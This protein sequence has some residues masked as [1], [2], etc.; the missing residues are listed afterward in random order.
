MP[1]DQECF[2]KGA[3]DY[4]TQEHPEPNAAWTGDISRFL[5]EAVDF[6]SGWK[7]NFLPKA[8]DNFP[9]N[10]DDGS[11]YVPIDAEAGTYCAD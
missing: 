2:L 9:W 6:L 10:L 3:A 5:V 11:L 4:P 8:A 1:P 7:R